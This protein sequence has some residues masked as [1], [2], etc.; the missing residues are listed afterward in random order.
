MVRGTTQSFIVKL[1][2]IKGDNYPIEELSSYCV[3][4]GRGRKVFTEVTGKFADT[5][6]TVDE[7]GASFVITLTE[8]QSLALRPGECIV[9]V[10]VRWKNDAVMVSNQIC[11]DVDDVLCTQEMNDHE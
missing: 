2:D 4:F 8:E 11:I 6:V 9:Q 10:K 3:C 7:N 1:P 5:D